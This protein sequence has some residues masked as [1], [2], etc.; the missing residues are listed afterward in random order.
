MSD[1][2]FNQWLHNSGTGG[3][4]QVDGG[5]VGIGTTNP[6]IAV[7]SGNNKIL[8]VGIVTASTY[9]GDG[10]NLTGITDNVVTINN[11]ANNRVITGSGSANTLEG[12]ATFTYSNSGSAAILNLKRSTTT[13]QETILYY[14]ANYFDIETREATG[15]RLKTNTGDR[16]IINADGKIGVSRVATQH[17]LEIG[18]ASE[19]TLSLWRGSTKSAALQAQSGGTY[20]Y[21][22]ENAPLLFSVNSAQ[23]FTER[24]RISSSGEM[25][26]GLTQ[27]APTGSFTMRLTETPEFNIYS[28]QQAQNNNIKINFGV[29]Q[30][31][32]VSGNTGARIEMNIPN[33]GGQMTGELKF[34]TNS[35]D[36]LQER[37]RIL[38]NGAITC[39][40]GA[41][42]NLHG[43]STTG[44]CL[45]GN[46]NSGQIIANADGNR[47][48]IIGRQSS[49]GQV[50]EFFQGSGGSNTNMAG[51]TIPAADTLGLE[52]NGSEKFRIKGDGIIEIGT[53]IGASSDANI[54]LRL[55]RATDCYLGI[56]ATGNNTAETGIKF[57]DASSEHDGKFAYQHY[58]QR[59]R[60][61]V[62]GNDRIFIEQNGD[63]KGQSSNANIIGF[64]GAKTTAGTTNWNDSTNARSGN[65]YTLL[66]GSHSN[67]PGPGL[68]YHPF[69]FEYT[70]RDGNGNM[71][72]LAIPYNGGA[73][74]SRYR[75]S[76]SWSGW[77]SH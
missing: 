33:A 59:F 9:Y 32:S 4:S 28:T 26:L 42:F 61:T 17:P 38:S 52:T 70:S 73:I 12:E 34:H 16:L 68:Y 23:G 56:R 58:Y 14:D 53:S 65:G 6:E 25:G 47:A 44:I 57:G 18:H 39:G 36:N 15:I 43:S 21:S 37:L 8:N 71:T 67:G 76:G 22:Y 63:L 20:L 54:R 3:V 35:G 19:P 40:H 77:N 2:R 31:A 48:L 41:N 45:N 13:N 60:I 69:T 55:G 10:S 27:D 24:L 49:F 75:Y 7:H 74:Y 51:I 50:I 46:G 5:H 72:Q 11:N 64:M 29:G 1:I 30:S 62:G 66:L